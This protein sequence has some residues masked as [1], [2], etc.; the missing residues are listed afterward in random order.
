GADVAFRLDRGLLVRELRVVTL[1]VQH[2]HPHPD[3]TRHGLTAGRQAMTADSH[4]FHMGR[5]TQIRG[6]L[7]RAGHNGGGPMPPQPRSIR[8]R[9]RAGRLT[10]SSHLRS[11]VITVMRYVRCVAWGAPPK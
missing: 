9:S 10:V 11:I 6:A 4:K 7:W 1:T 3:D 2:E 8:A 5:A